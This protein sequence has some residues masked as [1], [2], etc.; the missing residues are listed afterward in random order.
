MLL[1]ALGLWGLAHIR[2]S[3]DPI[4]M[5]T[6]YNPDTARVLSLLNFLTFHI[7]SDFWPVTQVL[8]FPLPFGHK[9]REK[10]EQIKDCAQE[11]EEWGAVILQTRQK[12]K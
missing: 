6:L 1:C 4:T 2:V 9:R 12:V 11:E 10:A 3:E 5:G 8:P 7:H